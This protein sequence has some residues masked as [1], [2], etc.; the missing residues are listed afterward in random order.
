MK[1][2]K[3]QRENRKVKHHEEMPTGILDKENG[4]QVGVT[5]DA[6]TFDN[7]ISLYFPLDTEYRKNTTW[8]M[9]DETALTLRLLKD[10]NGNYLWNHTN[11]TILGKPV[12]ISNDM[13]SAENGKMPVV[14]GDFSYYWIGDRQGITFKRLDELFSMTGQVGFLA[15]KRVDGKLILPEAVKLLAVK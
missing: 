14:F 1:D 10:E 12:I 15:S 11:D 7:I 4:A 5:D 3:R 13:P 8:L 9:N 2:R 6:I